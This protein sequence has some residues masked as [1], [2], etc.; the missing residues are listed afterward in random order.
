MDLE[1]SRCLL[2]PYFLLFSISYINLFV[3]LFPID[4]NYENL[5]LIFG[6]TYLFRIIHIRFSIYYCKGKGSGYI[7]RLS[8]RLLIYR[9][10][11]WT[12]LGR[13]KKTILNMIISCFCGCCCSRLL[14]ILLFLLFLFMYY[15]F[16]IFK[17]VCVSE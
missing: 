2:R 12:D 1:L 16:K 4:A 14:L 8:F 17:Y 9:K 5:L 6:S 13:V 3:Y 11:L 10:I 15:F 7:A